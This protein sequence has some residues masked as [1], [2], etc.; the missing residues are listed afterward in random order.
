MLPKNIWNFVVGILIIILTKC[1]CHFIRLTVVLGMALLRLRRSATFCGAVQW[2]WYLFS[3]RFGAG[4][5]LLIRAG[6]WQP[7]RAANTFSIQTLTFIQTSRVSPR[8][9]SLSLVFEYFYS[10]D[11]VS[12]WIV[13]VASRGK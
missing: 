12:D 6:I 3:R 4:R 8:L 1:I 11:G 2:L 9:I 5:V 10:S 13:L 7:Q